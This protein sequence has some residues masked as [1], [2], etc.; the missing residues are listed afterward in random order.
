MVAEAQG[1][2][3]KCW[4]MDLSQEYLILGRGAIN[5]VALTGVIRGSRMGLSYGAEI[6]LLYGVLGP[7]LSLLEGLG[8]Q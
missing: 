3:L 2:R 4:K 5:P 7:Y 8:V 6:S 1:R